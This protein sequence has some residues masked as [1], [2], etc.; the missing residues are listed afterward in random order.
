MKVL[1][2]NFRYFLFFVFFHWGICNVSYAQTL[3]SMSQVGTTTL[4]NHNYMSVSNTV[5][6]YSDPANGVDPQTNGKIVGA[7]VAKTVK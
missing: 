6:V 3:I 2:L 5:S 1:D 7:E 4:D